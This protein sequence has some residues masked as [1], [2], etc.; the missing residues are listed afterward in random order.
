MPSPKL[1][2]LPPELIQGELSRRSLKE[3]IRFFW[4]MVEPSGPFVDGF[5]IDAICEHLN[6]L[7]NRQIRNLLINIPP[8]HAKSTLCGVFFPAWNWLHRPEEQYLYTSYSYGLAERDSQRCRRLIDLPQFQRCYGH[9]FK[10]MPDQNTKRRFSNDKGGARLCTSVLGATTGEGGSVIVVDDPHS[11]TEAESEVR[12]ENVRRWFADVFFNR[13]NDPATGCRL[14]VGQRIH[15]EDLSGYILEHYKEEWTHLNLPYEYCKATAVP[16]RIGWK[17]PRQLDG[18]PL[19]PERFPES[20]INQLKKKPRSFAAQFNQNPLD[21]QNALFKPETFRYFDQHGEGYRLGNRR[22]GRADCW[23]IVT[24]D[25]AISTKTGADF[26]VI[27]VVDL[28]REGDVILVDM[29]RDRMPGTKIVPTL[30]E[31]NRLYAPA[32]FIIED[33]VFQRVIVEQARLEA[34]LPVRGVV[35]RADKETRSIPLQV[36]F[37]NGQVW[38]PKD[39]PWTKAVETELIQFPNGAHDDIV[40]ALAYAAD[41]ANRHCRIKARPVVAPTPTK[42]EAELYAELLWQGT[43]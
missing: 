10:P 4:P 23:R 39:R 3:F 41:E 38:F 19:W 29:V 18:Q 43:G 16:T 21:V 7:V 35:P 27:L 28:S 9:L 5:H 8:R 22:I 42:T 1:T 11:V 20:E 15:N 12:R 25:L 26:T 32:Y 34:G 36:R 13:L 2:A 31:V 37:E 40:D 24:T 14:V 6:A 30:S 17:D 33:V